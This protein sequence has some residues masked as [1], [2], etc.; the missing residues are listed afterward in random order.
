MAWKLHDYGYKMLRHPRHGAYLNSQMVPCSEVRKMSG[1]R[2]TC[3]DLLESGLVDYIF[4]TSAKGRDPQR[5]SV[6][7]RRKA[8]EL[9]IPCITAVDTA[10]SLVDCLRSEHSW[11]TSRWW[12]SPPCIAASKPCNYP[13]KRIKIDFYTAP[14]ETV[15]AVFVRGAR[16]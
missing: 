8:V 2:P 11:Q 1:E 12:I 7:L 9:S 10:A 16:N 6:K 13:R 4:S 15:G 14:A 5:D 3:V